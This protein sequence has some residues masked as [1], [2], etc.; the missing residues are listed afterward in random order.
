ME[1]SLLHNMGGDSV[2]YKYFHYVL[3]Y[4]SD[5]LVCIYIM[6]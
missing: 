3:D 5:L 1:D 4:N 6:H 2:R